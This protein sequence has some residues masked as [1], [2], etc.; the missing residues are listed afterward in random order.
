[1]KNTTL[2]QFSPDKPKRLLL[3]CREN[4]EFKR[5]HQSFTSLSSKKTIAMNNSIAQVCCVAAA[6][7]AAAALYHSRTAQRQIEEHALSGQGD[8]ASIEASSSVMKNPHLVQNI[9]DFVG[10]GQHL[11]VSTINFLVHECHSTVQAIKCPVYRDGALT[12]IVVGPQMTQFSE[13]CRSQSR[14]MLAVRCGLQLGP[15]ASVLRCVAEDLLAACSNGYRHK[16]AMREE[17]L[18]KHGVALGRYADKALLTF[19]YK[20]LGLP[21]FS[22][23]IIMGAVMSGDLE[24]L[25][26]LYLVG[27]A[28]ML[29]ES[30]ILAARYGHT[31]ILERFYDIKFSIHVDTSREAALQGHLDVLQLLHAHGHVW[32]SETCKAAVEGGHMDVLLWLV[33]HGCTYH[34]N[35]IIVQAARYG[36]IDILD[37]LLLQQGSRLDV[38]MMH[39]AAAN[40]QLLMCQHL[41]SKG[42]D[43]DI[44]VCAAAARYGHVSVLQYVREHGCPTSDWGCTIAACMGGSVAVL[45]YILNSGMALVQDVT[46]MMWIAGAHNNL[47]AVQWL[48]QQGAEWPAAFTQTQGNGFK[49]EWSGEVLTW[50]IA[51]GCTAPMTIL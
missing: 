12:D 41:R 51:N 28:A 29:S 22:A 36:H 20:Q 38:D 44:N 40:G 5:K 43:W 45:E 3:N 10:P 21:C 4:Q 6:V 27:Y 49:T 37:W 9:L 50:A 16:L 1:V 25:Q 13:M 17:K 14:L 35:G 18:S 33:E 48:K 46:E 23:C 47:T 39:A 32:H 8:A 34:V 42:C 30:S 15:H 7:G 19:A 11:Y 26:W 2:A 31:N 24:K